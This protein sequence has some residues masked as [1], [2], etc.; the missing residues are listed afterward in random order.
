M[1]KLPK[2]NELPEAY[3]W[4][5][6]TIYPDES[7][8]EADFN[9]VK[10]LIPRIQA[11]QGTLGNSAAQL[12]GC[13][14]LRDETSKPLE[15]LLVYARMRKDEDNANN[16]YQALSDRAMVLATQFSSA[17]AFLVPE[18]LAMPEDKLQGFLTAEP[19]LEL[20]KHYLDELLRQRPHVRSTEVEVVLAQASEVTR[21]SDNS[22]GML[23][24]ADMKFPTIKDEQGNDVELSQSRYGQFRESPDRRVRSEAFKAMHNSYQNFRNTLASSLS[25]SVRSDIFYARARNY[26]SSL[27][28]ALGPNNIPTQVYTNLVE[29]VNKNLSLLQRYMSLRKRLLGLDELHHY[30]LYV[31]MVADVE[32]KMPYDEAAQTVLEALSPLGTEYQ[33]VLKNG[34]SSRWV[35]VY[36]N[37]GK[38]S[39]A[40]SGG[41]YTT[42]PF[43]LMNYQGTLTDVFT[44]AHELGHSMHSYFTR[45]TQ[46]YIYGD[47]TIFLAEVAS[48]LNETLLTAFLLKR[49][50]DRK[51]RS[52]LVNQQLERFRTTLYRQTM[53]AEFELD[54]HSRAEAGEGLTPDML[55]SLY[56]D[57]NARYY[58]KEVMPD[59]EIAIEWA[60]IPHFY[61]AFYVYQYA[62]GISA[63]AALAHQI[64]TEG[65]PAVQRYIRFLKSG[66]SNYSIDLLRDAG[67]DMTSPA[68]VQQAL[69]SFSEMLDQM[70][71]LTA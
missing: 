68:P 6:E 8:W 60:R 7:Q 54:I 70:E 71:E 62:T 43:V 19:K 48:T 14:E 65:E 34:L 58:G 57:L 12:L 10:D 2:R 32:V 40:Y 37:E 5:L 3:T 47:Y 52:Y 26:P 66:S 18:I 20:Y 44:L 30:D 59:P 56:A 17:T 22:Y 16:H 36:E 46:R 28:A 69:D 35:D 61:W 39:G 63:A 23:T 45:N 29:T 55:S 27:E 53:F 41:S 11:L 33:G 4:N 49:T 1:E 13:L 15:Q 25:G 42:Y 24:N 31:P 9:R 51:L 67:V 64:L 38:T 50:N 21:T